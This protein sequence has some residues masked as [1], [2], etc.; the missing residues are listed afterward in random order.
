MGVVLMVALVLAGIA[1]VALLV[2]QFGTYTSD[3]APVT[4]FQFEAESLGDGVGKNDSVTITHV[5]G[6]KLERDRIEI[7]VD[8]MT[9]YNET[10]DSESTNSGF[11]VPGLVVEVDPGNDFNDLN[12]PCRVDGKRVS[13]KGT[14]G[15]PPGDGDGSDPS[16]V[17]E[18]AENVT[19]GQ[20]LV[21]QERNHTNSYDV[22]QPGDTIKI[23][24]HGEDFSAILAEWTVD[25]ETDDDT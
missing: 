5:G 14:C 13:P 8:G 20:T 23:L 1:M 15:G 16:V 7:T 2:P 17:L 9:V 10:A 24:Y 18:W 12:K 25:S 4:D 6:D 22:I 11:A 21:I 3:P 19:A